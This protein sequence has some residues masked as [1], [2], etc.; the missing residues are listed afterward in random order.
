[1]SIFENRVGGLEGFVRRVEGLRSGVWG[2]A[3]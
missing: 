2:V 1:M 3:V